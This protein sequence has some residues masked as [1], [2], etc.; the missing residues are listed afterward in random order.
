MPPNEIKNEHMVVAIIGF[1]AML[2]NIK[3]PL[4]ISP[5]PHKKAENIFS[6]IPILLSL[7]IMNE[8]IG[9]DIITSIKTKVKQITPPI[10]RIDEIEELMLSENVMRGLTMFALFWGSS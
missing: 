6:F 3:Q 2:E 10:N 1:S 9:L 8:N 7:W 5:I 4:V